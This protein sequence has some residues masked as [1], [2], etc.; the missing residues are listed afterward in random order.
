MI[1]YRIFLA[2]IFTLVI[3]LDKISSVFSDK[4]DTF[5]YRSLMTA[6]YCVAS[7][8]WTFSIFHYSTE[9]YTYLISITVSFSVLV[10][11]TFKNLTAEKK[12]VAVPDFKYLIGMTGKISHPYDMSS[13][14]KGF[15]GQIDN[16]NEL[17]FF[18]SDEVFETNDRFKIIDIKG[19]NIIVKKEISNE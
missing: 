12:D 9:L 1:P 2:A 14:E 19:E 3:I 6:V 15:I 10:Y 4:K 11:M 13:T 8:Y 16:T 18:K 5:I 7:F 17:V